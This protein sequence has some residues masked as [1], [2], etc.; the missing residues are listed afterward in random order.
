MRV[1]TSLPRGF[2]LGPYEIIATLGSGGMGTVYRAADDRLGRQVAIKQLRADLSADPALRQRFE[3]EARAAAAINHPHIC[4]LHDIGDHEGQ[5]FLVMELLEGETLSARL[6]RSSGGLPVAE[7]LTIGAQVAEGLAAA[8]RHGIVHRDV[9]PANIMLTKTGAKLVDFGV[10]R[11]RETSDM[12]VETLTRT[13]ISD[14]HVL[15]GTL[16][17]MA[18]EQLEGSADARTDIFA[19]GNVL[20]EMATGRRAFVADSAATLIAAIVHTMPPPITTVRPEAP[21]ALAR[22]ISRCLAKDADKRWQ[23]AADLA[24]ELRWMASTDTTTAPS[25]PP[26]AKVSGWL[27]ALGVIAAL[28]LGVGGYVF[29]LSRSAPVALS[30]YVDDLE[31]PPGTTHW[32]G[33]A[34]APDGRQLALVSQP[35]R[36][37]LRDPRLWVREV[38]GVGNWRLV[39]GAGDE[40]PRYPFWSPDSRALAYSVSGKLV[41]ADLSSLASVPLADAPDGRGGAWLDDGTIVYA[42]TPTSGLWKVSA[43]GGPAA[44]V[45]DRQADEIGLKFPIRVGANHIVYWS[46]NENPAQSSLQLLDLADP[47]N[48]KLVTVSGSG[49]A[50]DRGTLFFWR[51]GTLIGQRLDVATGQ[52][53][54]SLSRVAADAIPG[55]A[56]IGAPLVSAGAGHVMVAN[57]R[58]GLS[59]LT[60]VD[61][62]GRVI[63]HLGEPSAQTQPAVS[64]DGRQVVIQRQAPGD[65]RTGLWLLDIETGSGR[66]LT[67]GAEGSSPLWSPDGTQVLFRSLRGNGGNGNLYR[68]AIADPSRVEAVIEGAAAMSPAGWLSRGDGVVFIST[69]STGPIQV[70]TTVP[71]GIVVKP[72]DQQP[73]V[74]RSTGDYNEGRLSPD[75]SRIATVPSES[76]RDEVFVDTF[77]TPAPRPLQVSRGG[78]NRPMW[79]GDGQELYFRSE[80]RIMMLPTPIGVALDSARAVPLFTLPPDSGAADSYAVTPDGNRFLLVVPTAADVPTVKLTLNWQP[81]P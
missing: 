61:R 9:K 67:P 45:I 23:S 79:R 74:F 39:S 58:L 43:N 76:G 38:G 14:E 41:R 22:A 37:G 8:H 73:W 15:A 47:A 20:F 51:D 3:R 36:P 35:V 60:W 54:G 63:G 78:G 42:P 18:P 13:A 30:T 33:L 32:A 52:L 28:A 40:T 77:P 34:I 68:L 6:Q 48:P 29:G 75:G 49:A 25:A 31:L 2:R 26:R 44:L 50:F 59:Q 19:L 12:S 5:A 24:E 62:T 69:T 27:P 80:N 57:R 70:R 71:S 66:P 46:Q 72:F 1:M 53:S 56:N 11:L 4:T 7:V 10:A 64:P 55:P 81:E 17:Y 65:N 16:P 21:T